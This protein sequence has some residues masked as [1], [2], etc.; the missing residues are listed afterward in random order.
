M[1]HRAVWSVLQ[2]ESHVEQTITDL[3]GLRELFLTARAVALFDEPPNLVVGPGLGR[4]DRREDIEH[5]VGLVKRVIECLPD[6]ARCSPGAAAY[7]VH[8]GHAPC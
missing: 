2:D 7:E 4:P 1:P 8:R 6:P 5:G 3:V